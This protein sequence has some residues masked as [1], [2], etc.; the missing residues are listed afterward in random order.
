MDVKSKQW[1]ISL[2]VAIAVVLGILGG[3]VAYVDP[4]FHYHGPL[5]TIEYLLDNERYQNDGIVKHF[6]YDAIICG[7]SMTECFKTSDMDAIFGT[8]SIKV[9]FS[10]GSFK[11]VNNLLNVAAQYNGNITKIVRCLD[12]NRLFDD[13]DLMD[14]EDYPEYLYDNNPFNDVKYLF[15]MTALLRAVQNV[16]G[17]DS[18]GRIETSFDKYANWMFKEPCSK[19]VVNA[20]YNRE[21]LTY[22]GMQYDI[23][24]EE[25]K[26][27]DANI[28]QNVIDFAVAHPEIDIYLYFSPYNIYY[29]DFFYQNGNMKRQLLAER[30][31]IEKLLPIDN[32]HLYSFFDNHELMWNLDLYKDIGHHS[33]TVNTK[34]LQWIKDGTGLLTVDNYEAYCDAEYEYFMNLDYDAMYAELSGRNDVI[35]NH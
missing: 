30:Y 4:Y 20:N 24:A 23:S 2:L 33:E 6:D 14:Y 31:V 21:A 17:F 9:P 22:A 26:M 18:D 25:Y 12:Y 10:G 3:F 34:I 5:N 29:M 15:N 7:S 19:D 8:H 11:E 28:Q 1:A 27:L 32:I 16:L 13:K 35:L